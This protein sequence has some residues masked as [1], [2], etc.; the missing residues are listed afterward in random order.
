MVLMNQTVIISK[1]SV[2]N[3]SLSDSQDVIE[4]SIIKKESK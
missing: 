2:V 4:R 1:F 3:D